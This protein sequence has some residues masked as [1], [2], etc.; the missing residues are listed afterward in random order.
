MSMPN[1]KVQLV[2]KVQAMRECLHLE[3]VESVMRKYGLSES[4]AFRWFEEILEH[5]PEILHDEKPGPKSQLHTPSTLAAAPPRRRSR[6]VK[7]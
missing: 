7:R 1:R 6:S 4:S 5:L 2:L 3:N